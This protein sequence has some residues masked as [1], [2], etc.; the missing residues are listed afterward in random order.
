[1]YLDQRMQNVLVQF[2]Q[3]GLE[4]NIKVA[5]VELNRKSRVLK[6]K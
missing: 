1:M 6:N 2:L 3:T 4:L 5:I